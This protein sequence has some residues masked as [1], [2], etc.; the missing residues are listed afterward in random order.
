MFNERNSSMKITKN[1]L[2]VVLMVASMV[3]LSGCSGGADSLMEATIKI[4]PKGRA[5]IGKNAEEVE[6]KA[7]AATTA[8]DAMDKGVATTS[9]DVTTIMAAFNSPIN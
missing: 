8:R 9:A 1:I 2:M 7:I 3:V 5:Y 4:L 6:K